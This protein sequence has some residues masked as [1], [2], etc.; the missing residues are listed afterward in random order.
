VINREGGRRDE[1]VRRWQTATYGPWNV[2]CGQTT[3]A[4]TR[5]RDHHERVP[6]PTGREYKA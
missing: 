4:G 5:F 3:S 6:D 2:G 1:V